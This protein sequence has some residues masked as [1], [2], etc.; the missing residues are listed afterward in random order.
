MEGGAAKR[1]DSEVVGKNRKWVFCEPVQVWSA[2]LVVG[3]RNI[4]LAVAPTLQRDN[5]IRTENRAQYCPS[6]ILDE[7]S[8]ATY[9]TESI[10][11]SFS[12]SRISR[13]EFAA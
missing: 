2:R 10:L 5:A 12:I 13:P 11:R 9:T 8:T 7:H 3:I 4:L 6:E 1:S